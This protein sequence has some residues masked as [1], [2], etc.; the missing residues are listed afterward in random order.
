MGERQ[1]LVK[2]RANEK[3]IVHLEWPSKNG[4]D[5]YRGTNSVGFDRN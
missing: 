1:E 4:V 5:T 3:Q 2:E